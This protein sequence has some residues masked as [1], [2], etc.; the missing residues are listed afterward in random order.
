MSASLLVDETVH[1]KD[2]EVGDQEMMNCAAGAKVVRE[3]DQFEKRR[4][5]NFF[6]LTKENEMVGSLSTSCTN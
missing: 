4:V 3:V 6:G 2:F 5:Q 1:F